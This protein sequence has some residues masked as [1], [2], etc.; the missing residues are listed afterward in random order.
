LYLHFHGS[1]Y[2]GAKLVT[3]SD[4]NSIYSNLIGWQEHQDVFLDNLKPILTKS[5]ET[6]HGIGELHGIKVKRI[7]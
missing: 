1:K 6:K 3:F 5:K 4:Y 2:E 7:L